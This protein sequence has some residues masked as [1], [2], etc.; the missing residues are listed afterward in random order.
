MVTRLVICIGNVA[1]RDDGVAASVARLLAEQPDLPAVA[2]IVESVDLDFAMAAEVAQT[3][4]LV[5]V[6]AAQRSDP[7]VTVEPIVP[8]KARTA[9]G[10]SIDAPSLLALAEALYGSSP[11][12]VLVSVAAPEMGHGVGLSHTAEAAC[13]QAA[14]TVLRILGEGL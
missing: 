4:L 11:Q 1:R 13:T 6:D 8:G 2:R 10:H 14:S 3:E 12:A 7:P 5:I 9:T